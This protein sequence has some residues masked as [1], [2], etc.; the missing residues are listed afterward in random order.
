MKPPFIRNPY[1]Y[2]TEEAS[3][4]AAYV[5]K[6]PSMT[7]QSQALDTDINEIVRRY[8]ITG[9]FPENHRIPEYGDFT[10]IKDFQSAI[11]AIETAQTNFMQLP[12][13]T[14]AFFDNNPQKLLEF[15]ANPANIEQAR[16]MHLNVRQTNKSANTTG[17]PG[18]SHATSSG[19]PQAGTQP[20]SG[21]PPSA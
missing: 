1:N 4:Q 20:N 5:E 12:A 3:N 19:G 11:A 17:H 18:T 9:Q 13:N 2:D 15:C 8:G 6:L 10:E 21:K 7:I 16:Q 14:R